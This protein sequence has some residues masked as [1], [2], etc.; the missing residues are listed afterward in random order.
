MLRTALIALVAALAAAQYAPAAAVFDP[1]SNGQKLQQANYISSPCT[2]APT[3]PSTAMCFLENTNTD[4][5]APHL[6]GEHR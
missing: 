3:A 6:L 1:R 2:V 4:Q 5:P